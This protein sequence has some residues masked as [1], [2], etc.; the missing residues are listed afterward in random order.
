M[1]E[2]LSHQFEAHVGEGP[3]SL[4][5]DAKNPNGTLSS[6][7]RVYWELEPL[8]RVMDYYKMFFMQKAEVL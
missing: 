1:L 3:F 8:N 6:M 7:I 4:Y 5:E 2:Y